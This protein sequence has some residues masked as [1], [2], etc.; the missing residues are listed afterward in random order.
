MDIFFHFSPLWFLQEVLS[1]NP[2]LGNQA[3]QARQKHQGSSSLSYPASRLQPLLPYLPIQKDDGTLNPGP[4]DCR[5]GPSSCDGRSQ[6]LSESF[7]LG[8][9]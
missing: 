6:P 4:H 1:L 8:F 7:S 2:G 9:S 3:R 5:A